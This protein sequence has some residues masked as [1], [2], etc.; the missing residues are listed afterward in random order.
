MI[1]LDSIFWHIDQFDLALFFHCYWDLSRCPSSNIWQRRQ[2]II[3]WCKWL[4]CTL[5][6]SIRKISVVLSP[7]KTQLVD[8][9][10]TWWGS[11][12]YLM[13][14][15][16]RQTVHD[17]F[18][19]QWPPIVWNLDFCMRFR[20]CRKWTGLYSFLRKCSA[21]INHLIFPHLF[22]FCSFPLSQPRQSDCSRVNLELRG[23]S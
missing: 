10:V 23:K 2:K 21:A 6:F 18:N 3:E 11:W 16:K 20:S 22:M 1:H 9:L 12:R 13:T 19:S 7:A 14:F 4:S 17:T 8:G 15:T 5:R